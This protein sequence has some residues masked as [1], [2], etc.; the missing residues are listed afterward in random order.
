MKEKCPSEHYQQ[1]TSKY[2]V[3]EVIDIS[4]LD[5]DISV[6]RE[7]LK[8]EW[9]NVHIHILYIIFPGFQCKKESLRTL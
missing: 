4:I 6:P 9:V 7:T 5:H 3:I 2:F 8:P 1:F